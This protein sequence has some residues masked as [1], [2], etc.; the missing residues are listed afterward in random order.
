MALRGLAATYLARGEFHKARNSYEEATTILAKKLPQNHPKVLETVYLGALI[1]LAVGHL[2]EAERLFSECLRTWKGTYGDAYSLV[3]EAQIGLAHVYAAQ[4]RHHLASAAFSSALT[5]TH[6]HLQDSFVLLTAEQKIAATIKAAGNLHTYMRHTLDTMRDNNETVTDCFE[7]WLGT[8]GLLL[9]SQRAEHEAL[10]AENDPENAELWLEYLKIRRQIARY[11]FE[12]GLNRKEKI[13]IQSL[14]A[15]KEDMEREIARLTNETGFFR[16][17]RGAS[18]AALVDS[19]PAGSIYIDFALVGGVA[20]D[21]SR[22]T[23]RRYV[24]FVAK[25]RSPDSV[26][27]VDIGD[28][29]EI[30]TLVRGL[31]DSFD[32]KVPDQ[33]AQRLNNL[34]FRVLVAP[35]AHATDGATQIVISPDSQLWLVPFAALRA[36]NGEFLLDRVHVTYSPSGRDICRPIGKKKSINSALI[37][38]DPD[39]DAVV[40][41][42][43]DTEWTRR[44]RRMRGP[45][46]GVVFRRLPGTRIEG[47]GV[48]RI[49]E[50]HGLIVTYLEGPN[51]TESVLREAEAPDVLHL[52]THGYYLSPVVWRQQANLPSGLLPSDLGGIPAYAGDSPLSRSGIALAG[53]NHYVRKN[54]DFGLLTAEK[55]LEFDLRGTELVV[56][57]ACD[58]ALGSIQ[59]GDGVFGLTRSIL[60]AGADSAIVTLWPVDDQ[61]TALLMT[62]FYSEW[63]QGQP[64]GEALRRAQ[65]FVRQ[66][67]PEPSIWAPFIIVGD[68]S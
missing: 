40:Q 32:P 27:L 5:T 63:V 65:Q 57:S 43:P 13:A 7:L 37:L 15:K 66:S 22:N 34:L 6:A 16:S 50:T 52:A 19:L 48:G 9:E 59:N 1:E 20:G 8:K 30:N 41:T 38:F 62:R 36:P 29:A 56:L 14:E 51:A 68:A 33:I 11:W 23:R 39:Y 61:A 3:P 10:L 53:V 26:E 45:L 46:S 25:A 28:A 4:G 44:S 47:V 54:R 58:T 12:G 21:K 49:L 60:I 67:H 2:E 18:S 42:G 64:K 55:M 31:L 17:V 35:F 24:A